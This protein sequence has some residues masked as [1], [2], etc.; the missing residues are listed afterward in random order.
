M[1]TQAQSQFNILLI[2]DAGVDIYVYGS[3]NRISPEAP[4]P[5]FEPNDRIV[6]D[7]MAGNVAN[8]LR[9]LGCN[10]TFLFAKVSE[11]ERLIDYR[12]KQQ[13]L[14][15]DRDVISNPV[16][17]DNV[18]LEG[19][20]AVVVSDYNKGTIS[21]TLI[22]QLRQSFSG[23]I[24]V[25]TKKT[26]LDKL[27]GCIVKINAYEYSLAT[28]YCSNLIVTVGDKGA[29][30]NN[31]T[32][33]TDSVDIADV[34]GAGDTFLSA[35]AWQ[36]LTLNNMQ[37]AIKYANRAASITVQNVGVYAPTREEIK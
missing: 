35:L 12:S 21:Y 33:P 13:L 2:G 10:V 34:C 31:Q 24:F 16:T 23:P 7:G 5:I 30:W 32:F 37:E 18:N 4:V 25:D 9:A 20:D 6:K 36:Y 22:Q 17:I 3:V 27:E 28:S 15:I 1:T 29:T 8:N 19:Y 11:K 26:E 14:R